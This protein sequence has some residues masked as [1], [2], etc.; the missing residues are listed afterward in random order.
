MR[1]CC[2]K[3]RSWA[4]RP[5]SFDQP[6]DVHSEPLLA[7]N[8]GLPEKD[9]RSAKAELLKAQLQGDKDIFS[10]KSALRL[11]IRARERLEREL[12][13]AGI[14]PFVFDRTVEN[15]VLIVAH[16]PEIKMAR[17]KEEQACD[18]RFYGLLKEE[19]C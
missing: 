2:E 13:Q 15:M 17:V 6:H 3:L 4:F 5:S 14:E 16:V 8:G 10:A 19:L 9:L 12:S 18:A 7:A 1:S 11:A